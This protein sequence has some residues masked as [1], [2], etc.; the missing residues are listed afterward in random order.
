MAMLHLDYQQ[1]RPFHWAGP[2]LLALALAALALTVA[3]YLELNDRAAG[4]EARL[5]Q[6]E[7]RQGLRPSAKNSA[8]NPAGIFAGRGQAGLALEVG[9]ANEV[10]RQLTLPWEQLFQAVESAGS[11]HIALLALEPDIE[12]KLVKINGEARDIA[13]LLNYITRLEK[14]E[15]F[16]PVYLQS[17]QVQQ[18]SERSVRFSLLA[19]WRGTP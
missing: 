10:V 8:G 4:W 6:A 2:V 5:E 17:H 1:E 18:G 16:G 12:K 11:K 19:V 13:V 15:V 9:R 7:L 3:Y 14:Q